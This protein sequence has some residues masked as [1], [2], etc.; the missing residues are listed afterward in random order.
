[1]SYYQ[2]LIILRKNNVIASSLVSPSVCLR[3]LLTCGVAPQS[4]VARMRW[5]PVLQPW[6]GSALVWLWACLFKLLK[7]TWVCR[8]RRLGGR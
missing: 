2:A 8:R 1:M 4:G 5:S 3:L 6:C 7:C